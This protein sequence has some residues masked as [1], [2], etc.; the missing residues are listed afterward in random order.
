MRNGSK[1]NSE[2]FYKLVTY[3]YR[4][5]KNKSLRKKFRNLV[6]IQDVIYS[7]THFVGEKLRFLYFYFLIF[8]KFK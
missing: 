5:F 2:V 4:L 3:L 1:Y 7:N 6:E 8:F